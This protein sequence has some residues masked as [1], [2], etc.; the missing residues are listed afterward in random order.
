MTA[1]DVLAREISGVWVIVDDDGLV[2]DSHD[3][4]TVALQPPVTDTLLSG[5]DWERASEYL[6]RGAFVLE[7][8][9]LG[10]QHLPAGR[11][12]IYVMHH[13]PQLRP[14]QLR[15][16]GGMR[17]VTPDGEILRPPRIEKV[18]L[19]LLAVA[20][21][22]AGR[23]SRAE[24][25]AM[26]WPGKP[27]KAARDSLRVLIR[28]VRDRERAALGGILVTEEAKDGLHLNETDFTFDLEMLFATF[29][30][31]AALLRDRHE[32]AACV[33]AD[34]TLR[35]LLSQGDDLALR[36]EEMDLLPE[37]ESIARRAEIELSLITAVI[38]GR[39]RRIGAPFPQRL[40]LLERMMRSM[41]RTTLL[42]W[43]AVRE[44][45]EH[46]MPHAAHVF[47]D[48]FYA[49][50]SPDPLPFEEMAR[51]AQKGALLPE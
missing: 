22:R 33:V 25:A 37:T 15:F 39:S 43:I 40:E 42:A 3:P 47:Y 7:D 10:Q 18:Q 45:R 24:I 16:M 13:L 6:E 11:R 36:F 4:D 49:P 17:A 5:A 2:I 14:F 9:V 30:V 41:R 31:V 34:R 27:P 48:R 35:W 20:L 19:L 21:G 23:I 32:S 12:L 44:A 8:V 28:R 46:D 38:V 29:T 26:L 50:V 51:I 1:L